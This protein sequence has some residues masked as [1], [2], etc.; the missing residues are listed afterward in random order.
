MSHPQTLEGLRSGQYKGARKLKLS[1][2]LASFPREILSLFD[3]LEILDLSNNPLSSLPS[4][5][6][7]LHKLRIAFFSD[8]RFTTFPPQLAKC[9]S[10]EMI[11]FK[12]NHMT[13]IPEA[14]FPRNLR[15]LILTNNEIESIP[16]TIG[17]CHKLQK[18]ML[19][20]NRLT[21]LP[22][23][24]AHC[25]K[26]GLLR[27]SS[28]SLTTLPDWLFQL[29]ELSF[30]SFAGNPCASSFA[31]NPIL[32]DI[33]WSELAVHK[34]LGEGAS[35]II[36]KGTWNSASGNREV[37]IKIFKGELTSDGSPLDEMDACITA[38]QH[39]NLINPI[40]KIHGHPEKKGLVLQLIPPHYKNL[41]L[42]PDFST[43]TRDRFAPETVFSV[44]QCKAILYGIA[45][46][47]R[48]IHARGIA[49]GDL[50]A[51]NILIDDAGHALLGDFGAATIYGNSEK[52][53]AIERMEVLA[54][55]HL[56]EDLLGLVEHDFAGQDLL[57]EKDESVI[58]GLNALHYLCTNP[59]VM[60]RP[61][62]TEVV[63]VLGGL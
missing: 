32:D 62:F 9:R 23:D 39:P 16:A 5:F 63:E 56:I 7:R 48:H 55:G 17:Y 47:A 21:S 12:N 10:L 37:A 33:S 49:H 41:G 11:A 31:D 24:M 52:K 38:G 36:S 4:D 51:H 29:P 44:R 53:E 20:G 34:L 45:D 19:A 13:T 26:L 35:G 3:S 30:L 50:Y 46:A 61:D 57:E 18:C 22:V 60:E 40:G 28:N 43:C 6:C 14:S 42:P 25:R 2:D 15:W 27:L 58:E 59:I 1:A 54:F 8:C